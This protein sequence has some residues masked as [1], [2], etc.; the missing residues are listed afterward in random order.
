MSDPIRSRTYAR[1]RTFDLECP[2]CGQLYVIRYAG[3]REPWWDPVRS[4]LRCNGCNRAYVVG[5]ALWPKPQGP[6]AKGRPLDQVPSR[7]TLQSLRGALMTEKAR[8]DSR[9]RTARTLAIVEAAR[10]ERLS[11]APGQGK[12][13][14]RVEGG[15]C[16]CQ[17]QPTPLQFLKVPGSEAECPVHGRKVDK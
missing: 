13:R 2:Y 1:P 8:R 16:T 9:G 5:L 11:G 15:G 14:E 6:G 17:Y 7:H 3:Q 10:G 4:E 12:G